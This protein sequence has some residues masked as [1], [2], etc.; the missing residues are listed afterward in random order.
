M[1]LLT[2]RH[3]KSNPLQ[4]RSASVQIL[5]ASPSFSPK[6][7]SYI[8]PAS[9]KGYLL[10]SDLEYARNALQV[11]SLSSRRSQSVPHKST[12]NAKFVNSIENRWNQI[13]NGDETLRKSVIENNDEQS[14]FRIACRMTKEVVDDLM[15][16]QEEYYRK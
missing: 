15:R 12:N 13:L 5:I 2:K 9:R 6:I 1:M 11:K 7:Q 4:S 8:K 10:P 16:E 14:A 3:I